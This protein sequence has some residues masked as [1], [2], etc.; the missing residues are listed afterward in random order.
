MATMMTMMTYGSL[1]SYVMVERFLISYF[2]GDMGHTRAR[3]FSAHGQT[4]TDIVVFW[5][6]CKLKIPTPPTTA[7][8]PTTAQLTKVT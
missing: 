2:D 7:A 6:I 3:R 4:A 8:T 1:I 5:F